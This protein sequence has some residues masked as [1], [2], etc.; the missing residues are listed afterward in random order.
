MA[1]PGYPRRTHEQTV[2]VEVGLRKQRFTIHPS[3]L[4]NN[5]KFF[6]AAVSIRWRSR[7][8][9]PISLAEEDPTTFQAYVSYVYSGQISDHATTADSS[10]PESSE[11]EHARRRF[12]LLGDLF[13]LGDHIEDKG[14]RNSVIDVLLDTSGKTGSAYTRTLIERAFEETQENSAL[15]RYVVDSALAYMSQEWLETNYDFLP[16]LFLKRVML[17]WAN[18]TV[19]KGPKH[20]LPL[21]MPTC[22]YHEHDEE[23]PR[24]ESCRASSVSAVQANK[25]RKLQTK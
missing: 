24:D 6:E 11:A 2:V 5:S 15:C 12:M 21:D 9:D 18:S 1:S 16:A 13:V 19:D 17:G 22:T 14:L 23:M 25:R 8:G 4:S 3:I 10:S 20:K 7:T